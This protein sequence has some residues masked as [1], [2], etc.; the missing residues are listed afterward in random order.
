MGLKLLFLFIVVNGSII[1]ELL[2]NTFY[3]LKHI[4]RDKTKMENK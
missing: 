2:S 4:I 1:K 3:I